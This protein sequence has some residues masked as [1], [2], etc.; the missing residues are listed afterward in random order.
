MSQL[1]I[2]VPAANLE[3]SPAN[4]RKSSDPEADARLAANIA[5]RGVLQNLVGVPITRK[6]GYYRITA[7][8]RRLDAVH[9]LIAAGIFPADYALPLLV[10]QDPKDAVEV[11]LSENFFRLAMNPAEACRAFRDVIE[12]EGKSPADVAKRFGVTERFVQGRLRLAGL[13]E[14]VFDALEGNEI[15]LDVAKA[16]ASTADTARQAAVFELLRHSYSRD[17]VGEIRRQLASYSY[18]AGDPKALLVGRD[19]YVAAGGRIE[20]DLFSDAGSERWLDT[21]ILDEL[22]ESRLAEAAEAIRQREG[23]GEIRT[24]AATHV[25]YNQTWGLRQLHGD[26]PDLSEEQ[27]ARKDEIEIELAEWSAAL[28]TGEFEPGDEDEAHIEALAAELAGF[29]EPVPV[30]EAG[31]KATALA[32][33]ILDEDGT[34]RIHEQLYAMPAPEPEL[35]ARADSEG[36]GCD[37]DDAMPSHGEEA[38]AD[39]PVLS[40]RLLERLAMMKVELLAL[41]VASDPA[42][43]LDLAGFILADASVMTY[44]H[45]VP[46]ELRGPEPMRLVTDFISDMPAARE[47]AKL[48]DGLDRSWQ[49]HGSVVERFDDFCALPEEARAAWLGWAVARTL[50]AVPHGRGEAGFLDH[51]G[52]R[53][54]IDVA[55]WWRPTA[56]AYFDKINKPAILD[57]F[58]EIGGAD[59]RARYAGSKKHDLA[60]AAERLFSG[61][62]L[63]EAEV[64]E[65]AL[66]WLPEAMRFERRET[67]GAGP[68][69]ADGE[70]YG[71]EQLEVVDS[72]PAEA[73]I[74]VYIDGQGTDVEG[75]DPLADAA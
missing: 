72:E 54:D 68:I 13:A 43:A 38:G 41:H 21:Q 71:A 6:K 16:Y 27:Q 31:V 10:L 35:E 61:D 52:V 20:E 18:R 74:G 9:R 1:P 56:A 26:L 51:L 4:V 42:F 66:A 49:G 2:L 12:V 32:Y 55:S 15:T 64:K 63:V 17:N 58:E 39:R 8:G 60:A 40:Q 19:A 29:T 47:W 7:G 70:G 25:P 14:P 45:H 65:R 23:F 24:V 22:A 48:Q 3:K 5:E 50:R 11:S 62:M 44:G 67:A 53:L 37:C 30:I 36:D 69:M 28:D 57:L 34:P 59:L 75:G 33:V 73:D 46:S